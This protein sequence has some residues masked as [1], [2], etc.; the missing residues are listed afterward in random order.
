RRP[1]HPAAAVTVERLGETVIELD[2]ST[3]WEP[4]EE[5]LLRPRSRPWIAAFLVVVATLLLVAAGDRVGLPPPV[6]RPPESSQVMLITADRLY[7][8]TQPARNPV[9]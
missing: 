6:L 2:V 3:R 4:A 7:T 8:V 1:H 9:M 5:P